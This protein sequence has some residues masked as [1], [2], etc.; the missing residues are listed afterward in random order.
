V[1]VNTEFEPPEVNEQRI[2][3]GLA[4]AGF[5]PIASLLKREA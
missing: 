1:T 2:L 4:V 5:A 3:E